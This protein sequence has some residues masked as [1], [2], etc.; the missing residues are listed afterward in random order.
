MLAEL[1]P[2]PQKL[3]SSLELEHLEHALLDDEMQ[4]KAGREVA[5]K[6][7]LDKAM[8]ELKQQLTVEIRGAVQALHDKIVPQLAEQSKTIVAMIEALDECTVNLEMQKSVAGS[9]PQNESPKPKGDLPPQQ[10]VLELPRENGIAVSAEMAQLSAVAKL[11]EEMAKGNAVV[12]L[13]A[14]AKANEKTAKLNAEMAK[15][16]A[17]GQLNAKMGMGEE[18]GMDEAARVRIGTESP[19]F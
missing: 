13:S 19:V 9:S 15:L 12:K 18:D 2:S 6:E 1:H 7:D 17:T 10:K 4:E 5:T 11:N 14:V 3:S 16:S 8:R